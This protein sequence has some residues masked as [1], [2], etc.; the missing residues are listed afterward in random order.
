ML[1]EPFAACFL[2]LLFD[3]KKHMMNLLG[4]F[5]GVSKPLW[6]FPSKRVSII[7]IKLSSS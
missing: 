2:G 3:A 5:K 6:E 4:P 7:C 1:T